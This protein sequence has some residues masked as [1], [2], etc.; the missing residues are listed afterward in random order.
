MYELT[1]RWV[2]DGMEVEIITAP[3]EKSDI[4][5]SGMISHQ[6]IE[7]IKLTIINSAD[8]NRLPKYK[9]FWRAMIFASFS[10]F[11]ALT[12]KYDL[13]LSSSGPISVGLPLVMAKIFRRKK[14]VFEVRD[15]WPWG[16]IEMGLITNKI[17]KK[18]G[19]W[20]EK[21]CYKKSDLLI[22][23]SPGQRDHINERFLGLPIE[24]IPN[25]SDNYL[26]EKK[27][28]NKLPIWAEGKIILSHIGSLGFIHNIPFWVDVA[29]QI[30]KRYPS[31]NFMFVFIGD[32][33]NKTDLEIK[34]DE[35]NIANFK[36]L[37]SL[38]KTELPFW[39]QNSFAT[40]FSTLNNPIQDTCSPNKIFD[41]FAAG[42]PIIQTSKGWIH[43]L[44]EK[45]GCGV[46]ISQKPELAADQIYHLT[47]KKVEVEKMGLKAKKLAKSQFDRE[48]LAHKYLNLMR[49]I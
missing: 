30:N 38:P 40:L 32:G 8:N 23:A 22:T 4:K 9:R 46:N 17:M 20:F 18:L 10:V 6:Q 29:F 37:G 16:G 27:T 42:K 26:F 47:D 24:V 35:L 25:A 2:R 43:D 5:S 7:G 11:F 41:S 12:K 39:L 31:N 1:R 15:L 49:E 36:L 19:L 34:I 21:I 45:Y 28:T 44:I 14:T 48:N 3:Y 13:I 33:A